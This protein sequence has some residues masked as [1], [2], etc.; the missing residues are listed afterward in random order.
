MAI[1]LPKRVLLL[2][3][4]SMT[5]L[6]MPGR[7]NQ[8]SGYTTTYTVYYNYCGQSPCIVGPQLCGY[9]AGEWERA[10]DGTL[11]GWGEEPGTSCTYTVPGAIVSCE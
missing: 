10:C 2:L 3:A 11:T 5:L 7:T 4:L 6:L 1:K 8:A 9:L